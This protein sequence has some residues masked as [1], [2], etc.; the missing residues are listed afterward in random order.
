LIVNQN[1]SRD[2]IAH[3]KPKKGCEVDEIFSG[4]VKELKKRKIRSRSASLISIFDSDKEIIDFAIELIND[5][6]SKV[7][8]IICPDKVHTYLESTKE[9]IS[10]PRYWSNKPVIE[11]IERD[12][13]LYQ[14]FWRYKHTEEVL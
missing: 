6:S 2:E 10:C 11:Q 3:V 14:N 13:S 4:S 12:I 8:F 1:I 7:K 9:G 5:Q